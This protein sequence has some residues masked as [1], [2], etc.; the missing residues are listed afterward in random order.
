MGNIYPVNKSG[1]CIGS[2]RSWFYQA[3]QRERYTSLSGVTN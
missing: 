3:I 2:M 1:P